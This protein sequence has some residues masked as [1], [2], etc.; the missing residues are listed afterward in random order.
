MSVRQAPPKAVRQRSG[1]Q[2][3]FSRWP[4]MHRC[5]RGL[6]SD[7]GNILHGEWV[8]HGMKVQWLRASLLGAALLLVGC[9][10]VTKHL[11]KTQ[12]ESG[13]PH[14][15]AAGIL[16]LNYT[17][18]TDSGFNLLRW[19][20][21][22]VR[23]PLL[24]AVQLVGG[25]VFLGLCLKRRPGVSARFALLALAAGALGNGLDRLAHGHVV[26]FIHLSHWPVFNVADI[27]VTVGGI[28]L[29]WTARQARIKQAAAS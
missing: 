14:T 22:A 18:N 13:P 11:A 6:L 27:Y 4:I 12:L 8:G 15:L 5:G 17:E 2:T 24:T 20:S 25:L 26:D 1:G 21:P 7:R 28:L 10:H 3:G 23:T 29:L 19:L 16:E 9:D